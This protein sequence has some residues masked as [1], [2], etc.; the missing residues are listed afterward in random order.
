MPLIDTP[1]TRIAINFIDQIHPPTEEEHR[2][3]LTVVDYATRYP[4]AVALK[5]IDTETVAEALIEIYSRVGVSKRGI[6]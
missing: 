1:F 4:E 5:R 3:V 2:F 6:K